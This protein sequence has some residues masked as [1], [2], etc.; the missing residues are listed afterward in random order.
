M[1]KIAASAPYVGSAA[2]VVAGLTL[3]EWGMIFGIVL[4]FAT[5]VINWIYK[6]RKDRRETKILEHTLT[7]DQCRSNSD[8]GV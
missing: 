5:F 3:S 6:H 1:G 2:T 4:T 7:C 8:K